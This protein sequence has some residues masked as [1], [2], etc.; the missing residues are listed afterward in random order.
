MVYDLVQVDAFTRQV[1]GGN[2]AAVVV[3]S[4]WPPEPLM[5]QMAMENNLSETVFVKQEQGTWS[6]R[7]FTPQT[8]VDLC[9]HAT[10]AAAF[11]LFG[12]GHVDDRVLRLRSQSGELSV[13]REGECLFLD[14]PSRPGKPLTDLTPFEAATGC[15]PLAGFQAR[16]TLLILE[17]EADVLACEP[18]LQAV[19]ALDTFA[20]IV[21]GP[22]TDSD[23]VS[24]FFAPAAGIPEDPVT[25][26]AHCT[27]IPYWADRLAKSELHARQL[28]SRGGELFCRLVGERVQIGGYCAEYMRGRVSIPGKPG[29]Q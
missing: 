17:T 13:I 6:I 3:L 20:V 27:L 7:W 23:F 11:V 29:G 9:G 12:D 10:L 21:S 14:F 5:Q 4:E 26:S 28:S 15:K 2:S 25:G 16:D 24:R 19:A 8:E 18:D 1:F 22:G